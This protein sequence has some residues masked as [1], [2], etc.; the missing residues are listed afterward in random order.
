M[1]ENNNDFF[2]FDMDTNIF[3]KL[4]NDKISIK[5]S[6]NN[7]QKL[8]NKKRKSNI[9]SSW[10][11]GNV[12]SEEK[13]I[14]KIK[15]TKKIKEL[16]LSQTE[17]D[18][19]IDN[20]ET[21]PKQNSEIPLIEENEQDSEDENPY[22]KDKFENALFAKGIS[23]TNFNLSKLIIKALSEMEY[24]T[25]TKVQEK[26]IPIAL[27]GHDIFVNSETGSGKTACFLL[28]IVQRIIF[29]RNSKENKKNKNENNIIQ[30]QAL[31]IVP[32]RELALQCN[33][34]L[35]Q[36]LKYIDLNFVFLCGGLSVENQLKQMKNKIPD[37]IITTPG[38]LLDLIYNN[39]NLS[40]EHVNILVL[41]E[42]DKLLE[43]GFKDAIFEILE[44]IKKN[45]NRQTLLFS[46]TLNP[47][48]LDLGEHALNNPIKIKIA[49]SAILTNLS[50]SIIRIKFANLEQN[51]Y[52]KRMAY[53]LSIIKQKKLNRTIIF[54]NTK[55]D[56]HKCI[57][58]FSKFGLDSCV[59]LHGDKSQTERIKS[60]EDFQKGNVKFLIATDIAGRGID[61][62][63]VK[64]VINF[65][66]PLIGER[67]I[68]RVGRTARKGYVGEAITICDDKERLL[69]KKI[70][71]KEKVDIKV[72][73]IKIN[74]DEIKD[75]YKKIIKIKD[76]IDN[77][78]IDE[79]A[80]KQFEMAEKD[81]E[82][83]MNI[84]LH[85][86]EIKNRPKKIWYE[87]TKEKRKKAKKLKKE[88]EKKKK[89]LYEDLEN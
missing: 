12:L 29:S 13:K 6:S 88:F 58:Y 82:K 63:K 83:T 23:F 14:Q 55:Q 52:E 25:P 70:F 20:E 65:Q 81:I 38:R 1:R 45:K 17:K 30:N 15:E 11:Y 10:S 56:C 71:K 60:L 77:K 27:N 62:E 31:I 32:T 40:L 76:E 68:H 18:K 87:T 3:E 67:Y 51:N 75:L 69:I 64:C 85:Q 78:I 26:V 59:E 89:D 74:N 86:N 22:F 37:I 24:Y 5:E 49:Q 28:P 7:S 54:F 48:L 66:M 35:T 61:I 33:E 39:K 47:K 4:E 41:D 80:E 53:L 9:N 73:P 79:K 43:L 8:L 19:E 50:Q 46:A 2:D 36:F 16:G 42:A 84:K 72:K 21:E 44:L 57:L 34:M